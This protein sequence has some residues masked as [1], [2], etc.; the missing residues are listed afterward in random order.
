M[1]AMSLTILDRHLYDEQLAA[2]ILGLPASTLHWWLEG[3]ERQGRQYEPVLRR[4][5]TGAREVTWG[6]LVEAQYLKA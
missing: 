1:V 2:Q 3:G 6:E 4:E 5:P